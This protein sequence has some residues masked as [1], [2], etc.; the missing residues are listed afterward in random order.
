MT[1]DEDSPA[2]RPLPVSGARPDDRAACA[3]TGEVSV[4]RRVRTPA[5][6]AELLT[7]R[8][9]WLRRQAG[10]QRIPCTFLGRHLRFSDRDLDAIVAAGSRPAKA[11]LRSNRPRRR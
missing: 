11:A 2:A 10:Q 8:E 6:A 1:S 3:A 7:V 5:E 9:S 4:G